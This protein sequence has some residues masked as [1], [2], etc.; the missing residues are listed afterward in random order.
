MAIEN[1][2]F[3][4]NLFSYLGQIFFGGV[5]KTQF[6]KKSDQIVPLRQKLG[7]TQVSN[8]EKFILSHLASLSGHST[9]V[10]NLG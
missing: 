8:R 4:R 1:S 5:P 2:L 9:S 7:L 6:K 3:S 10:W